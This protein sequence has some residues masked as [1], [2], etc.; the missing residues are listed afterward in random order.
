MIKRLLIFGIGTS[1]IQVIVFY[2]VIFI[3]YWFAAAITYPS[4]SE[5]NSDYVMLF[6][7]IV[8]AII[9]LIQN[10]IAAI[11]NRIKVTYILMGIALASYTATLID[12]GILVPFKTGL[13]MIFGFVVLGIKTTIDD[14]LL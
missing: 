6:T 8:F 3:V 1:L 13:C 9:V 11:I 5:S 2:F 4:S 10:V 7:A 12:L 14:R